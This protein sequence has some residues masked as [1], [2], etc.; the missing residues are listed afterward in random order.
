[1]R[2]SAVKY[3]ILAAQLEDVGVGP[4]VA[5]ALEAIDR[6]IAAVA[7]VPRAVAGANVVRVGV[8]HAEAPL[9]RLPGVT[10]R[11]DQ[12]V[13]R[14]MLEV[15]MLVTCGKGEPTVLIGE[16]AVAVR[17]HVLE[18]TADEDVTVADVRGRNGEP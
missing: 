13:R 14:V 18:R 2:V 11:V 16:A 15:E 9:G 10:A 7:V 5:D 17:I 6:E 3:E 8:Q 4:A 12:S 1:M